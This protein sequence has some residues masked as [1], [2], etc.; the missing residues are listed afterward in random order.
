M[1]NEKNGFS[2][3][4]EIFKLEEENRTKDI[5][6]KIIDIRMNNSDN[7]KDIKEN[8]LSFGKDDEIIEKQEFDEELNEEELVFNSILEDLNTNILINVKEDE[9]DKNQMACREILEILRYPRSHKNI[10][11]VKSPFKPL[12]QP[13]KIS[14]VGKILYNSADEDDNKTRENTINVHNDDK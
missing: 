5:A 2:E 3:K 9:E 7:E 8:V 1:E 6:F 12:Y 4:L 13:K 10:R 11:G 14:M